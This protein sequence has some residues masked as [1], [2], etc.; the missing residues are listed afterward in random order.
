M[1]PPRLPEIV[2]RERLAAKAPAKRYEVRQREGQRYYYQPDWIDLLLQR[3]H[4]ERRHATALRMLQALA[5]ACLHQPP[6]TFGYDPRS[7]GHSE[8]TDEQADRWEHLH[9]ALR[10]V[11]DRSMLLRCVIDGG[12][13]SD[14]VALRRALDA[15]DVH[16]DTMA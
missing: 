9:R 6:T 1:K 13:C 15:L 14:L 2:P 12:P 10:A 8:M 4:L 7:R 5:T 11:S 3:G 16:F